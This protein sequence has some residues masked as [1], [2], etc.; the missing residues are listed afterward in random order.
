MESKWITGKDL[1][2]RWNIPDFQIVEYV[3]QGLQPYNDV[4]KP[5]IPPGVAKSFDI[6]REHWEDIASIEAKFPDFKNRYRTID[7][8]C[9]LNID[10]RDDS[11]GKFKNIDYPDGSDT[12]I[13]AEYES[14]RTE[15]EVLETRLNQHPDLPSWKGYELP[16]RNKEIESV[17]AILLN[18][19]FK[20]DD[21]I[22][23][24]QTVESKESLPMDDYPSQK[25]RGKAVENAF[26]RHVYSWE[27]WYQGKKLNPI[28]NVD[29][30]HYIAHLLNNFGKAI[31]VSDLYETLHAKQGNAMVSGVEL[32]Q[33][34]L[35]GEMWDS[36]MTLEGLDDTAKKQIWIKIK[37]LK[38]DIENAESD[39]ERHQSKEEL[40]GYYKSLGIYGKDPLSWK[41]TKVQNESVKKSADAVRKAINGAIGKIRK[42]SPEL[43]DYLAEGSTINR[44]TNYKYIDKMIWDVSF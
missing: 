11:T 6:I 15:I 23:I 9:E 34:V 32:S 3:Q 40:K 22:E 37:Q 18:S 39:Y 19:H 5:M 10:T 12:D 2:K 31:H 30:I 29:G 16:C 42:E 21:V 7:W 26:I 43:A 38:E 27:I 8:W 24:E 17:I 1:V 4:G 13:R 44:G 36:D 25:D 28:Q 35:T 20:L 14:K 33:S 41:A